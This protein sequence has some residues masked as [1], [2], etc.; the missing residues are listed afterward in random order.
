MIIHPP[1]ATAIGDDEIVSKIKFTQFEMW[2]FSLV[3]F[4]AAVET[5]IDDDDY[6]DD[7]DERVWGPKKSANMSKN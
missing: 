6:G 4:F 3:I 5:T 1:Q 2:K 7:D